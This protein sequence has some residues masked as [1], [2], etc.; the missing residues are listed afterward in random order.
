[1]NDIRRGNVGLHRGNGHGAAGSSGWLHAFFAG[2]V[3]IALTLLGV[4]VPTAAVAAEP[5]AKADIQKKLADV[6]GAGFTEPGTFEVGS[7]VRY[8]LTLSCSSLTALPD[9]LE[10]LGP[11][12]HGERGLCRSALARV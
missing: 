9:S 12:G 4:M 6:Q 1:M 3:A 11:D 10:H 7:L 8:Q 5:A 2:V